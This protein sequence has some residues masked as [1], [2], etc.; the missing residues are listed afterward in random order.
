MADRLAAVPARR[1][2]SQNPRSSPSA[3]MARLIIY[4]R[5]GAGSCPPAGEALSKGIPTEHP[6]PRVLPTMPPNRVSSTF[7]PE[8]QQP[9]RIQRLHRPAIQA[10]RFQRL[11]PKSSNLPMA[12]E[13]AQSSP[14]TALLIGP[15][16]R[17]TISLF[18][19]FP[20]RP[21]PLRC[22]AVALVSCYQVYQPFLKESRAGWVIVTNFRIGNCLR[23]GD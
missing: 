6:P 23:R 20:Q 15:L 12:Q 4:L 2:R 5:R 17:R 9:P 13:L 11:Q 3:T 14:P 16:C 7:F 21:A 10:T 22:W 1:T 19:L 18:F 8:S